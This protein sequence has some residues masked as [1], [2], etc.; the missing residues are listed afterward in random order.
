[1][2][3]RYTMDTYSESVEKATGLIEATTRRLSNGEK[4]EAARAHAAVAQ[5]E[6]IAAVACAIE[7]SAG[8]SGNEQSG[9][10]QEHGT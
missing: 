3:R 5:A 2:I 9:W 10:M 7:G 1:M 6:A 4:L 8:S